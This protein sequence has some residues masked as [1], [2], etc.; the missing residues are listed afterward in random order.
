MVAPGFKVGPYGSGR[1][2]ILAM[3]MR[4]RYR[5]MSIKIGMRSHR[6]VEGSTFSSDPESPLLP[7]LNGNMASKATVV[8]TFERIGLLCEQPLI[9]DTGLRLL[10]G[11]TPRATGAQL[12]VAMGIEINKI[13][14]PAAHRFRRRP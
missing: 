10:C 9:S 14:L 1:E 6:V 11:H 8:L 2:P 4:P 7:N 12:F 3:L 13:W 5:S